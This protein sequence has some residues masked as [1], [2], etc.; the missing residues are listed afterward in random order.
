[1]K[2]EENYRST[3]NIL[4]AANSV[5]QN[6]TERKPKTL[7][8]NNPEGE[9]SLFQGETERQEAIFIADQIQKGHGE[10][11]QNYGEFALLYRTHAQSRLLKKNL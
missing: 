7:W 10:K 3:Q 8:T 6:N 2:L 9:K 4:A 11:G 5:I 1:M